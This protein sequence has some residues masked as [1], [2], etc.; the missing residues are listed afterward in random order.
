M[1]KEHEEIVNEARHRGP[2]LGAVGVVYAVLF[3][4]SLAATASLTKGDHIPLPF[5]SARLVQVLI[6]GNGDAVSLAAFLQF[7][8]AVPLGIFVAT[9]V[10]RLQFLG[11]NVAG[12]FITLFGGF[13]ASL[14]LAISALLQW[15]LARPELGS[16]ADITHVLHLLSFATGGVGFVVTFG[17]FLAGVSVIAWFTRILPRWLVVLGLVI[18]AFAQVSSLS[19]IFIRA[20]YLLAVVRFM[21]LIWMIATGLLLPRSSAEPQK[22][23]LRYVAA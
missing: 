14:F 15:T 9:V 10:S 5:I 23:R 13:A 21:G 19:L 3:L 12:V 1:K 11:V 7:G 8:A 2:N 16:Q 4:A 17:L 20:T 6:T 18:T 22:N